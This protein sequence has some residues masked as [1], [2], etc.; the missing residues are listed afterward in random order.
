MKQLV[1]EKLPPGA[2]PD[3]AWI[4]IERTYRVAAY[5]SLQISLG[6]SVNVRPGETVREA[7]H[8]AFAELKPEFDDVAE[9]L[10]AEHGV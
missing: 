10:R 1:E 5:E 4:G 9:L 8:R 3:R 2:Q 7:T 6:A